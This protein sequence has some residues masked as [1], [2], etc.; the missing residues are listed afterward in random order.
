VEATLAPALR[1]TLQTHAAGTFLLGHG[2]DSL[3]IERFEVHGAPE[4]ERARVPF[5]EYVRS[6]TRWRYFSITAPDP[7]QRNRVL[8]LAEIERLSGTPH[9]ESPLHELGLGDYDLAR[10]L[11][12]DG[13]SL[14]CWVGALQPEPFRDEQVDAFRA[15]VPALQ[16]RLVLE[17]QMLRG[18]ALD[19][20]LDA[21]GA[22]AVFLTAAGAVE[23][24]NEAGRVMLERD[25]HAVV[26]SI[27]DAVARRPSEIPVRLVPLSGR[28]TGYLALLS[29]R[30]IEERL[31]TQAA[32]AGEQWGLTLKEREVLALLARGYSNRTIADGLGITHR[33]A[34]FHVSSIFDRAGVANRAALLSLLLE[35]D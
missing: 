24:A 14:L 4:V 23:H 19:T 20:A 9:E 13:P 1:E 28:A 6:R 16:W 31:A 30:T 3:T 12:C 35:G 22:P 25:R 17:R 34:E 21:L 32:R 5:E 8:T 15:I 29:G 2:F 11:V 26:E 10:V 18:A 27:V 7:Q 33:C